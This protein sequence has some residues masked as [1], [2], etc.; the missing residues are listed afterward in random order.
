MNI[1]KYLTCLSHY[2]IPYPFQKTAYPVKYTFNKNM[3]V[4]FFISILFEI[5]GSYHVTPLEFNKKTF[6]W[7]AEGEAGS[8]IL[9]KNI[10]RGTGTI[11]HIKKSLLV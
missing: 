1:D 5:C 7:A 8:N 4:I 2:I 6:S 10:T 11:I 9:A 3:N